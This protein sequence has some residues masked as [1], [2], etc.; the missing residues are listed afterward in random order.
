MDIFKNETKFWIIFPQYPRRVITTSMSPQACK[1][2]NWKR[3][4]NKTGV[5]ELL[6]EGNYARFKYCTSNF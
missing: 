2:S 5:A 3:L 6:L 4:I 1:I